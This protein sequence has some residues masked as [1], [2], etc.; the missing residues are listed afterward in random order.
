MLSEQLRIYEKYN[1]G[2]S[3]WLYKD[4]DI[5]GNIFPQSGPQITQ[6]LSHLGIVYTPREPMGHDPKA[7]FRQ[8]KG[9]AGRAWGYHP[10][11]EVDGLFQVTFPSSESSI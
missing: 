11:G 9:I 7:T 5:Q 4:I 3:I 6:L 10:P 8:E 2:W 1:V